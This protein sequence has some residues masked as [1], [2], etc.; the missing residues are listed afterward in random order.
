VLG[1]TLTP[2]ASPFLRGEAVRRRRQSLGRV[3]RSLPSQIVDTAT[4]LHLDIEAASLAG[5]PPGLSATI[6]DE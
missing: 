6:E 5:V 2:K 1:F 3:S 4:A